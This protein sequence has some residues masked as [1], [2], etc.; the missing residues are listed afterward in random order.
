MKAQKPLQTD[1]EEKDAKTNKDVRAKNSVRAVM[2]DRNES[3]ICIMALQP[4]DVL[5]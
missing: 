2:W 1:Q 5:K 3:F 4:N